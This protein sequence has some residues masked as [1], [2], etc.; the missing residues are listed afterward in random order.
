MTKF[1]RY[2]AAGIA[3]LM[4]AGLSACGD[5][6]SSTFIS[7]ETTAAPESSASPEAGENQAEELK[8]ADFKE[9]LDR[10]QSKKQGQSAHMEASFEM[11]AGGQSMSMAM[12]GDYAG[13]GDPDTMVMDMSIDVAGQQMQMKVVDQ[14]L[15]MKGP[16]MSASAGQAMGPGRPR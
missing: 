11:S 3:A 5:G 8:A 6:G 9:A 13:S 2:A 16:G 10:A 12:S 4:L 7:K 14:S 15:Y 1:R